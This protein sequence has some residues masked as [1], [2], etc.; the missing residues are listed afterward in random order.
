MKIVAVNGSYRK[1]G[2]IE[3]AIDALLAGAAEGGAAVEKINLVGK[4]IEF[5]RNCRTCM[6]YAGEVRGACVVHDDMAA[7]LEAIDA[8]DVVILASPMNFGTVTAV[9][10]QFI[11]R[12]ACYG[13]WP[14]G[15]PAPVPRIKHLHKGG[16]IIISSAMPAIMARWLTGMRG[17]LVQAL[18][19]LGAHVTSTL[20]IG[21]AGN[22]PQ[23]VLAG[24]ARR[25]AYTL[26]L[27]LA[28]G[29]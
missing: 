26:G 3:Q 19:A 24:R 14:W 7:L 11:E 17:V 1:G 29:V 22:A 8:A 20:M 15:A 16:V 2:T 27:R 6:Q 25:R 4:H 23:P 9:M 28:R 18:N 12:L 21:L 10:K 5:C 13:H